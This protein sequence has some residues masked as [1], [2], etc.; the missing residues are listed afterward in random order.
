MTHF[1]FQI[2]TGFL[3]VICYLLFGLVSVVSAQIA[4][5]ELVWEADSYTPPLYAGRALPTSDGNLRVFAFPP[6]S[7]GT[8]TNLIYTWKINGQVLGSMSGT[9]RSMLAIKGSPFISDQLVVVDVS[10]GSQTVTGVV[11][12]PYVKPTVLLYENSPLKGVQF[13]HALINKFVA[14]ANSDITLVAEPYFFST[15][16]SQSLTYTWSVNGQTSKGVSGPSFIA[17]SETTGTST[18]NVA[19][20][21]PLYILQRI[22]K[23]LSVVLQ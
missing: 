13:E 10:N 16:Q 11:R 4:S 3:F 5:V 23:S 17:R 7:L 22:S 19:V 6:S 15:P 2:S 9:D 21:N 14:E 8:A 1:K 20:T 18:V 12:I